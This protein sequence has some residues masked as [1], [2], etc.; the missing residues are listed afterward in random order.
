MSRPDPNKPK[1]KPELH[2]YM[3]WKLGKG[4]LTKRG[5]E[6]LLTFDEFKQVWAEHWSQRGTAKGK[7]CMIR[8]DHSQPYKIGNV[9]VAQVGK[10]NIDMSPG[11]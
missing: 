2:Q 6:Y 11:I 5:Q 10:Q 1:T 3:A 7:Y 8:L 4:R 9:K